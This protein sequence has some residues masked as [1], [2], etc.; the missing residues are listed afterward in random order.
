M[1]LIF[2]D[3]LYGVILGILFFVFIEIFRRTEIGKQNPMFLTLD[4]EIELILLMGVLSCV[5]RIVYTSLSG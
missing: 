1:N 3:F 2:V 4:L 5:K